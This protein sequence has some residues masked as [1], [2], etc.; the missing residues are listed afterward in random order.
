MYSLPSTSHTRAPFARF[1]KNGCPPTARNARTGEFTPPGMYFSASS[2]SSFDFECISDLAVSLSNRN[3]P[4]DAERLAGHFQ[5]GRGLA[6]LVFVQI[7]QP[8]DALHRSFV[9]S[10]RDDFRSGPALDHVGFEDRVEDVVRWQRVLV[11][12]VRAQFCGR[13]FGDGRSRDDFLVPVDPTREPIHH[14]LR[15]IANDRKTTAH[16]PVKRTV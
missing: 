2:K 6:A 3:T 1:T 4:P 15:H 16:V 12:L 14:C 8:H 11:G 5:S 9:K 7:N 13:R 10:A